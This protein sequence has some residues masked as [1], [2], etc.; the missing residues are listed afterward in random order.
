MTRRL[1]AGGWGAERDYHA[2]TLAASTA[3]FVKPE[4]ALIGRL[5]SKGWQ[6]PSALPDD[7]DTRRPAAGAGARDRPLP[8]AGEGRPRAAARAGAPGRAVLEPDRGGR[9]AAGD[10]GRGLWSSLPAASPW[11]VDPAAGVAGRLTFPWPR[12]VMAALLE[13]PPVEPAQAPLV[14]DAAGRE[15]GGLPAPA[16]D[17]VEEIRREPPRPALTLLSQR[18]WALLRGAARSGAAALRV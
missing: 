12:S 13:A 6:S 8:L 1:K 2:S 9:A 18:L 16:A 10:R 11:Y 7:P 15:A 17:V 5:M 14:R 4:D 3:S